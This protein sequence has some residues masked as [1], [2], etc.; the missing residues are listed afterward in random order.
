MGSHT[1]ICTIEKHHRAA[2]EKICIAMNLTDVTTPMMAKRGSIR[3]LDPVTGVQYSVSE[4][5]YVRRYIKGGWPSFNTQHM[6]QLNRVSTYK[7]ENG[8]Y[9]KN[10]I[11]A[12]IDEQITILINS[13]ANYRGTVQDRPYNR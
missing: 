2:I 1:R 6:Y 10:R 8:W 5:G 9:R 12:D 4:G 7:V 11:L 3:L 13:V